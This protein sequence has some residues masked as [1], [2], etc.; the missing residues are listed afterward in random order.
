V[1]V[2]IPDEQRKGKL[3]PLFEDHQWQVLKRVGSNQYY[4]CKR[5]DINK[6]SAV[7]YSRAQLKPIQC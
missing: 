6:V 2:K 1:L 4:L 7:L 5:D 3:S